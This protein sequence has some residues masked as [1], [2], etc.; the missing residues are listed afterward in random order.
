LDTNKQTPKPTSKDKHSIYTRLLGRFAPTFYFNCKH[1]L[2]VNIVKQKLVD[3]FKKSCIYKIFKNQ[4]LLEANFETLFI[5]LPWGHAGSHNKFGPDRFCR[6]DVYW[7][8]TYKTDTQRQTDKPKF[9]YRL[10]SCSCR[11]P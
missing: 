1:V 10:H 9:I 2:F 6:F 7:I 3:F 8:Q 5:N 11:E 4:I